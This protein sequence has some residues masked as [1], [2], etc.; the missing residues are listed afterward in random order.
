M[1][2]QQYYS[3]VTFK[4]FGTFWKNLEQNP[5]CKVYCHALPDNI[6]QIRSAE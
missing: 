2:H 1:W 3:G 5:M 6:S 4:T